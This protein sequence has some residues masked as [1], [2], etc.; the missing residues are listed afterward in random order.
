M[1]LLCLAHDPKAMRLM[2]L[3]FKVLFTMWHGAKNTSCPRLLNGTL[4]ENRITRRRNMGAVK[5]NVGKCKSSSAIGRRD[6]TNPW[7]KSTK[8]CGPT[9]DHRWNP[10][11]PGGMSTEHWGKSTEL[12]GKTADNRWDSPNHWRNPTKDRWKSTEDRGIPGKVRWKSSKQRW[13]WF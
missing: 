1:F 13:F 7:G 10:T 5:M 2:V 8:L 4:R 12:L 11:E 6:S 9:T 3:S